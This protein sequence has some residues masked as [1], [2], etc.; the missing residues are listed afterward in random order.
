M[1]LWVD[2]RTVAASLVLAASA[3][4][5][6]VVRGGL[7]GAS[8]SGKLGPG[9][10]AAIFG[11]QLAPGNETA[12][13]VP[14]STQLNGVRVTVGGVAAP[15]WFVAPNQLNA[16]IPFELQ[17]PSNNVA[18][19]VVITGAGSS[20]P[21]PIRLARNAPAIYTRNSAG[22]GAANAFDAV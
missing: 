16:L 14:L 3:G 9:T 6:P 8:Y 13:G 7:D 18:D 20:V 19:V 22:T 5:Q 17:I 15:L 11:E 4:A 10:W 1:R 21:F 12:S 2:W